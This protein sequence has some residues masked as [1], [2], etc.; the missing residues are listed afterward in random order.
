MNTENIQ[1]IQIK[2]PIGTAKI[3][4]NQYGISSIS[5]LTDSF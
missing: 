4:G 5:V 1:F 2:T 3:G